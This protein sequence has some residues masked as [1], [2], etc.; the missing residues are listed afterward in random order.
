MEERRRVR[1]SIRAARKAEFDA[2]RQKLL[3]ERQA[4]RDSIMNAR[5]NRGNGGL[6]EGDGTEEEEGEGNGN[7]EE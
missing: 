4:R 1:D 5:K 2:R 3:E 7:N 6:P